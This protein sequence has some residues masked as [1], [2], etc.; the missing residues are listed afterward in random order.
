MLQVRAG[1]LTPASDEYLAYRWRLCS[2]CWKRWGHATCG[3]IGG[4]YEACA[5]GTGGYVT[6]GRSAGGYA[7]R[8]RGGGKGMR[9]VP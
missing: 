9:H 7:R 4:G 6:S 3:G 5:G 8:A 2:I 1:Q